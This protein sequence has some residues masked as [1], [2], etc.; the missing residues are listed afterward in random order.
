MKRESERVGERGV[1]VV[2]VNGVAVTLRDIT[3]RGG[4]FRY[5]LVVDE[6]GCER[7]MLRKGKNT[8]TDTFPWQA[9][10][11]G[12]RERGYSELLGS[13]YETNGRERAIAAVLA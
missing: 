13:F 3:T 4:T 7:G 12:G 10:A 9:F 1:K 5:F 6:K 2:K 8:R 11:Y